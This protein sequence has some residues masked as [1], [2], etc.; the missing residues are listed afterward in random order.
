MCT[1]ADADRPGAH[2][3]PH[4]A[5]HA[6]RHPLR[7]LRPRAPVTGS[8]RIPPIGA[9]MS[10]PKRPI[11]PQTRYRPRPARFGAR[12]VHR[13]GRRTPRCTKPAPA[14]RH[15]PRHPLRPL[16]PRAPVTGSGRIPPI[17][18]EMSRPKRPIPPQT[19]YRPRPARFGAR[20]CAPGRTPDAPP[21][22]TRPERQPPTHRPSRGPPLDEPPLTER[23]VAAPRARAPYRPSPRG[24][25]R[26][27]R[28]PS[29]G[30][31]LRMPPAR[32]AARRSRARGPRRRGCCRSRPR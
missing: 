27:C 5:R 15:P 30:R 28:R 19:R 10:R 22:K 14:S 23:R 32:A 1:G 11:P 20:K 6:P 13:V 24:A 25:R 3:L 31:E 16:R 21:H 8:G 18:A 2:S 12:N 4:Y 9:E 26:P 29:A 17:G 7:P